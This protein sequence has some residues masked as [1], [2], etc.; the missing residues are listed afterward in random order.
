MY[1]R[2]IDPPAQNSIPVFEQLLSNCSTLMSIVGGSHCQYADEE[3]GCT[4]TEKLCGA[5]PSIT[6][7]EQFNVT[8]GL[9]LPWMNHFLKSGS[10]RPTWN[11]VQ[12]N[13]VNAV[14]DN[15]ALILGQRQSACS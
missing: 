5:N 3:I 7:D 12:E 15:R 14:R 6:R 9:I 2:S 13:L 11:T 10:D 8:I 4:L 1:V